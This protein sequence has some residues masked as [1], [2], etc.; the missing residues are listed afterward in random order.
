LL[1]VELCS[2]TL[3]R[4]DLSIPNLIASGLFGDGA[5]AVVLLGA[6]R[7][8]ALGLRGPKV[9]ATRSVFYRDTEDVMGWSVSER[10]FGIVLSESVP[11]VALE[12]LGPDVAS[13]LV[14]HQVSR[15]CIKS[16]I[17]HPGGPRVLE[18]MERSLQLD[19]EA[20]ALSWKVL[21]EQGNLSSSSV[22]MVLR[23]VLDG[24]CPARGELGLMLA[25]GPG[26][27]SEIALLEW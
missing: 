24:A 6:E 22:L 27:C 10:G 16:W 17:C 15:E 20:A 1:S 3:Q 13:F 7:A 11:T 25:M 2:L 12:R 9:R 18:A 4:Q 26:F 21:S 19:E 5:A 14:D 8:R 23:E